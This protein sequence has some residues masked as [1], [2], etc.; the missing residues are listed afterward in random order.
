MREADFVWDKEKLDRFIA[1][2]DAL[3]PGNR[4][5]PYSGLTSAADSARIIS[6]LQSVT[7][8]H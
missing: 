2:P 5:T 4:M 6:F 7:V 1:N 8:G 3:V